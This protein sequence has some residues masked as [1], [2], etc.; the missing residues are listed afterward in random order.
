MPLYKTNIN[1]RL[2]GHLLLVLFSLGQFSDWSKSR[3][4][5]V[6]K[7]TYGTG[8][9]SNTI[10]QS[11]HWHQGRFSLRNVFITSITYLGIGRGNADNGTV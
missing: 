3:M 4:H 5:H 6:K 1:L 7:S 9:T 2:D 8:M 11:N 10:G